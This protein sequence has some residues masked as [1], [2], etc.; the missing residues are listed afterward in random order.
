MRRCQ[1]CWASQTDELPVARVPTETLSRLA[2]ETSHNVDSPMTTDE[3]QRYASEVGR[4]VARDVTTSSRT[5]VRVSAEVTLWVVDGLPNL[6]ARFFGSDSLGFVA[7][8]EELLVFQGNERFP[9]TDVEALY[10]EFL[11]QVDEALQV[12]KRDDSELD[13]QG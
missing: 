2:D 7:Q 9:A 13:G 5:G 8:W 3:F 11:S 12:R 4:I 10:A 1:W 6:E